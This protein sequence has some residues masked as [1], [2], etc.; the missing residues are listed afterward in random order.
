VKTKRSLESPHP[1][2]PPVERIVSLAAQQTWRDFR[3]PSPAFP[4]H[5]TPPTCRACRIFLLFSPR[6][7]PCF[8]YLD[9]RVRNTLKTGYITSICF[10][11]FAHSLA[12]SPVF[13]ILTQ[14]IPSM[15]TP[16]AIS[17]SK[18]PPGISQSASKKTQPI[19]HLHGSC[20]CGG[21]AFLSCV[22]TPVTPC[23]GT[24]VTLRPPVR[25]AAMGAH[26]EQKPQ[27][28]KRRPRGKGRLFFV[29]AL[30]HV[31]VRRSG[32]GVCV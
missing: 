5:S 18:V 15:H 31:L 23:V 10:Q 14:N 8:Q 4:H 9:K 22:R 17:K 20:F 1:A 21:G 28:R 13:A 27:K 19:S 6:E 11:Y 3:G 12:V 2:P 24:S 25:A 16:A 26:I 7:L 29:F 30:E 32:L